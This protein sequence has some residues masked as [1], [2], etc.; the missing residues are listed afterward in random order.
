ML[1]GYAESGLQPGWWPI[2]SNNSLQTFLRIQ[3]D[4]AKGGK[5]VFV[6]NQGISSNLPSHLLLSNQR[7]GGRPDIPNFD[8]TPRIPDSSQQSPLPK[9]PTPTL[10]LKTREIPV[11]WS[12]LRSSANPVQYHP[13][14]SPRERPHVGENYIGRTGNKPFRTQVLTLTRMKTQRFVPKSTYLRENYLAKETLRRS[15]CV[16]IMSQWK[17]QRT[18]THSRIQKMKSFVSTITTLGTFR[19]GIRISFKAPFMSKLITDWPIQL[20]D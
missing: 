17:M 18:M 9:N 19:F 8:A 5:L 7:P 16:P 15:S 2:R 10:S 20:Y 11:N 6:V 14:I 1:W 13:P 4:L 3:Y 12:L